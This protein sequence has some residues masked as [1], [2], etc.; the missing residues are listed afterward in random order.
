MK[1]KALVIKLLSEIDSKINGERS[2]DVII[3]DERA[4]DAIAFGGTLGIG[5]AYMRGYFDVKRLDE[6]MTLAMEANLEQHIKKD[7]STIFY[8][9]LSKITNRQSKKRAFQVG[10]EH[11]NIGND[12]YSKML[13][14]RLVYTCAYFRSD[15]ETLDQAQENKLDLVCRKIGLKKGDHVLDIG[16]GWGSFA[17]FAAEKY[18]AR[19]TGVTVSKEQIELGEKLCA[20]L[21]VEFKL[22]DYRDIKGEFDHV[23]S[24]GMFEHV[25]PKN[26]RVYMEVVNRVLKDDGL[27]LLHTIGG[28]V[29]SIATDPFIDKYIFPNGVLP[30]VSQVATASEELFVMED[31][32]NFG[33]NYDKTLMCWYN[34]FQK[35]WPKPKT[36]P[37]KKRQRAS[38]RIQK[39]RL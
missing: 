6:L 39:E 35:A 1:S 9:L 31:L 14:K 28:N 23:I 11:Y 20:G 29:P 33:I 19:V 34:N 3:N 8:Y 5:E 15:D 21:P 36:K 2:T 18:G 4:Y 17:K 16:C 27:F 38:K 25:G 13:D 10:E 7:L 26:Y 24:L 32:H 30:S 22:M 12:L 37:A